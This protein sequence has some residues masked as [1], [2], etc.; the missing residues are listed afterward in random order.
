[1]FPVNRK[2]S[3]TTAPVKLAIKRD[4]KPRSI[5]NTEPINGMRI[6]K[7]GPPQWAGRDRFL[8]GLLGITIRL[9]S[10]LEG[11]FRMQLVS[12]LRCTRVRVK[13][14]ACYAAFGTH[15]GLGSCAASVF[16]LVGRRAW[17]HLNKLAYCICPMLYP[18]CRFASAHVNIVNASTPQ[19]A[20]IDYTG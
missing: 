2:T 9:N 15:I 20:A 19:S 11:G 5:P 16:C 8:S 10:T 1:M 13:S 3:L 14:P 12:V 4:T 18:T 7:K 6:N 17:E